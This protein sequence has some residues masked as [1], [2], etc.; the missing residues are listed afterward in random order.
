MLW[1]ITLLLT[2][3]SCFASSQPLVQE[4]RR[5]CVG[6]L[7]LGKSKPPASTTENFSI[8]NLKGLIERY[9]YEGDGFPTLQQ[10][11]LILWDGS[12]TERRLNYRIWKVD[13]LAD[14]MVD[15]TVDTKGRFSVFLE[16]QI[17]GKDNLYGN[18]T[19]AATLRVARIDPKTHKWVNKWV[20]HEEG[21]ARGSGNNP[22][23]R[24]T[25]FNIEMPTKVDP[26]LI[27]YT[28]NGEWSKSSLHILVSLILSLTIL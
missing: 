24:R 4:R 27:E 1:A 7:C 12:T 6:S 26:T 11:P 28:F 22:Y 21:L 10:V 8:G 17:T 19:G 23:P 13:G 3:A 9:D 2:L 5:L 14:I 16:V 18:F 15:A 25:V 20:N